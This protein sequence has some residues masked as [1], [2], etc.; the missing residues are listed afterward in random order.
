MS[1]TSNLFSPGP[2]TWAFPQSFANPKK[3]ILTHILTVAKYFVTLKCKSMETPDI[4]E[5]EDF[6][7]KN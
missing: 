1:D 6:L 7:C 3:R 2:T 4:I 5:C